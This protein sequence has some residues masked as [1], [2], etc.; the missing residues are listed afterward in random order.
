[1]NER[2]LSTVLHRSSVASGVSRASQDL[3]DD[4]GLRLSLGPKR[5][6]TDHPVLEDQKVALEPCCSGSVSDPFLNRF[7]QT[8]GDKSLKLCLET[9]QI[10]R[11]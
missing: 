4:H 8:A 10:R 5:A 11:H 9:I 2:S 6:P 7:V 1:M 3:L